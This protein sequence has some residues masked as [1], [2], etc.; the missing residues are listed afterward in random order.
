MPQSKKSTDA[1]ERYKRVDIGAIFAGR[2]GHDEQVPGAASR[3]VTEGAAG[4]TRARRRFGDACPQD[5][6]PTNDSGRLATGTVAYST[7]AS[8][9]GFQGLL[10]IRLGEGPRP[11]SLGLPKR[12]SVWHKTRRAE[13]SALTASTGRIIPGVVVTKPA[14]FVTVRQISDPERPP[15]S[16]GDGKIC[17]F[18]GPRQP[19]SVVDC[20]ASNRIFRA[21]RMSWPVTKFPPVT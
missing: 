15:D 8:E 20:R 16:W 10:G 12:G 18:P 17:A 4:R 5:S 1:D 21:R 7:D 3:H 6:L 11:A 14:A 19:A 2:P 9:L 13:Q